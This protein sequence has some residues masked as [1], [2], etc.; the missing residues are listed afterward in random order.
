MAVL[1]TSVHAA[2]ADAEY[3]LQSGLTYLNTGSVGPTPRSVL[4]AVTNAWNELE[5]NSE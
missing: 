2:S 4:E 1:S 5:T 3:G